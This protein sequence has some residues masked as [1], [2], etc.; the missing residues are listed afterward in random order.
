MQIKNTK[1]NDLKEIST[2]FIAEKAKKPYLQKLT[3]KESLDKLKNFFSKNDM[4][5]LEIDKVIIGFCVCEKRKNELYLSELWIG[6]KYQGKG[7]GKKI[8]KFAEDKYKSEFK[9]ITLVADRNA[10]AS[11]FYESLG[12]KIKNE[13]LKMT[14]KIK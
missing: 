5:T 1:E 7:Y 4:Y 6:E 2:I 9:T 3:Q 10:N 12:Y 11:K 14:K 13:W 8:M